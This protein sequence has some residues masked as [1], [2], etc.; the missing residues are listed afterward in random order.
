MLILEQNTVVIMVSVV[1]SGRRYNSVFNIESVL[2]ELIPELDEVWLARYNAAEERGE[3]NAALGQIFADA[4]FQMEMWV[5]E[6]THPQDYIQVSMRSNSLSREIRSTLSTAETFS[7]RAFFFQIL[8][9]LNSNEDFEFDDGF[10]FQIERIPFTGGAGRTVREQMK[11]ALTGTLEEF[12]KRTT[13]VW[14]PP[15]HLQKGICGPAALLLGAMYINGQRERPALFLRADATERVTN[16]EEQCRTLM[17]EAGVTLSGERLSINDMKDIIEQNHGMFGE[18][19][20]TIVDLNEGNNSVLFKHNVEKRVQLNIGLIFDHYVFIKS[21]APLMRKKS[22]FWCPVCERI[23]EAK[24]GHKC[25]RGVCPQCKCVA[26][27]HGQLVKC[28]ECRR[29][30]KSRQC[31]ENHKVDSLSPMYKNVCKE[32]T[33]CEFCSVD[34]AA[35]DGAPKK[36]KEGYYRDAYKIGKAAQHVC[37]R[38]K[39]FTCGETYDRLQTEN[40]KCAVRKLTTVDKLKEDRQKIRNYYCDFE[41][42][43]DKDE[44]GNDVYT[45]NVAVLKKYELTHDWTT[46]VTFRDVHYFLG[47]DAIVQFCDFLLFGE[48][49][50]L[51]RKVKA[52]VFAHNGGRFDW[53]PVLGEFTRRAKG[54][55]PQLIISGNT[56]KQFRVGSICLLD[57]KMF[58]PAPLA[59]FSSMFDLTVKKGWFP[60]AFNKESNEEYEGEIPD[61]G[62]FDK[63]IRE[64]EEFKK[65]HAELREQNYV[66]NFWDE[67]LSYCEDDV[68]VL[69]FGMEK[70]SDMVFQLTGVFPGGDNCSLASMANQAW[71]G[72]TEGLV[73]HIGVAPENGYSQDKQSQKA[74][75]WL[76]YQNAVHYG[77][78]LLYSGNSSNGEV[79]IKIRREVP[80][81]VVSGEN[82]AFRTVVSETRLKGIQA[83]TRQLLIDSEGLLSRELAEK[84]AIKEYDKKHRFVIH[85]QTVTTYKVDGYYEEEGEQKVILEF[86]GCLYHGCP[87][88]YD[89]KCVSPVTNEKMEEVL[90]KTLQ[91]EEELKKMG[92][93]IR[94]IW[95]CQWDAM[96]RG[97]IYGDVEFDEGV[98]EE[99]ICELQSTLDE[100]ELSKGQF[101]LDP[102]LPR[103]SLVGGRCGNARLYKECLEE[104]EEICYDD[105]TSLYPFVMR[106]RQ[107]PMGH[108]VRIRSNFNYTVNTY[109]GVAKAV[110]LPPRDLYHPILPVKV[111]DEEGNVKLMFPLCNQ[112]AVESNFVIDSCNHTEEERCVRGTWTTPELYFAMEN[113]YVLKKFVE[114]WNYPWKTDLCFKKYIDM[115]FKIKAQ[116]KG[117]PGWVETEADKRK[118][119]E[120]FARENGFELDMTEIK[121]DPSLYAIAKLFLNT[122]W[123]YFCKN[124]DEQQQTEIFTENGKFQ[125]WVNDDTK[126]KKNFCILDDNAILTTHKMRKE[127]KR[128]DCKGSIIHGAFTTAWARIHLAK[129]GLLKLRRRVLYFD[130]DSVIYVKKKNESGLPLGVKIGEFTNEVEPME[131][132]KGSGVKKPVYCSRFVSGGPKNYALEFCLR[133]EDG[134]IPAFENREV[135]GFKTVI[136]GF[137][138]GGDTQKILNFGTLSKIVLDSAEWANASDIE[139]RWMLQEDPKFK[140]WAAKGGSISKSG[141]INH[142]PPVIERFTV[143]IGD[144]QPVRGVQFRKRQR[145]TMDSGDEDEYNY[146]Y[147]DD[148]MRRQGC[149]RFRIAPAVLERQYKAIVTKRCP[150]FAEGEEQ[151]HLRPFGYKKQL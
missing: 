112:C 96:V 64:Q 61:V 150:V 45:V 148:K 1:E 60:H 109:F 119:C 104:G 126:E 90:N 137:S 111:R 103:E 147:D 13:S 3:R 136:R 124:P 98:D 141:L 118:Y 32:I 95:E 33:A 17:H 30:F 101:E 72:M 46:G 97:D 110:L 77:G 62:Y 91:R 78:Q 81:P 48:D 120:D 59:K 93:E 4:Q 117:F 80:L 28:S 146:D 105:I 49:S 9:V 89:P 131:H 55:N 100:I 75:Q 42:R 149:K 21:M 140:A 12:L 23:I 41:T 145:L 24:I 82:T 121:E 54:V 102:I 19:A 8:G 73:K 83:L 47:S 127:F 134:S 74:L 139:K 25:K 31:Y 44:D 70:F 133:N 88:C 106:A 6:N 99:M 18:Y 87:Q 71:R 84:M 43:V 151:F 51:N 107:Y 29:V 11:R 143:A 26:E 76:E 10:M 138:L 39:C 38:R 115:F 114:V 63:K 116:A 14:S 142:D 69:M 20:I 130:T 132:P 2:F 144:R 27:C 128:T 37:F 52:N 15:Q 56:I 65:W 35:K 67:I 113:G 66:W 58:V 16:F 122:L 129:E 36:D 34:L 22:G 40:H 50:L 123:G 108:P 53:H 135:V 86:Y 7:W 79:K 92:Y 94:S 125:Q 85:G 57:S 68:D 5:I